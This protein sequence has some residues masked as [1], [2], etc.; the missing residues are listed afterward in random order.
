MIAIGNM[1]EAAGELAYSADKATEKSIEQ[2]SFIG[3]PS[4]D[5]LAKYLDQAIAEKTIPYAATLGE[6][7]TANQAVARYTNLKNWYTAHGHFWVGTGPYLS[8]EP[9]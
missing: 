3:G 6:Y 5:I 2:M 8:T 9:S 4:M 1:A 7:I